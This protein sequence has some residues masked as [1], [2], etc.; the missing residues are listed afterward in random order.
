MECTSNINGFT[1]RWIIDDSTI[2]AVGQSS[3]NDTRIRTIDGKEYSLPST[4]LYY[5]VKNIIEK[6][7]KEKEISEEL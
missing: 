2:I 4:S 5:D 6:R 3:Y 7:N 1:F